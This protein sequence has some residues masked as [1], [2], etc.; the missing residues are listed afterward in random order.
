MIERILNFLFEKKLVTVPDGSVY[1]H[2]WY[3]IRTKP[4]A[5]FIHKFERSDYD[6]AL[7][8]HPCPFIVIPVW[9]GYLEHTPLGVRRVLPILGTRWRKAVFQHR[10]ELFSRDRG[11]HYAAVTGNERHEYLPAW[12]IFIRFRKVRHWGFWCKDGWKPYREGQ[13]DA[14]Q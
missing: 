10:V 3:T 13:G 8:D 14:C 7:H 12:S 11:Q 5:I 9:R 6:R 1:M 4:F 2:R